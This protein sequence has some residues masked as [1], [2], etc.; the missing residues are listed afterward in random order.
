MT[1]RLAAWLVHFYTAS[2]A[3][4]AL[5]ALRAVL[6]DDVRAAFAWLALQVAIDS[7]DGFLA[8]LVQVKAV[9]PDL[10]GNRLDDIVDYLT[11][12]FVPAIMVVH[13]GL[14][15]GWGGWAIAA[16]MLVSSAFGFSSAHAKTAD[17]FFTGF[18]SY[19]N[20]VVLYLVAFR[21]PQVVSAAL[22]A[23]LVVLVFVPIRYI[24]PSRTPVFQ[25]TTVALGAAWAVAMLVVIA[26][27]PDVSRPLL[28][29]SLAYPLYYVGLSLALEARRRR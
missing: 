16:G 10:D 22:L 12:V 8:R 7:T 25:R 23:V 5:L 15:P 6:L 29:A 1:R 24:Y 2:G 19:W 21:A 3:V 28:I 17:Y 4:C 13:Q 9:T 20:I 26:T 11:Y 27:L 18:P 14:V